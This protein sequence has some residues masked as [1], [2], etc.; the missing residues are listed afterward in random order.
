MEIK[1]SG[2]T[3]IK[4]NA[5]MGIQDKGEQTCVHLTLVSDDPSNP[6]TGASQVTTSLSLA[7]ANYIMEKHSFFRAEHALLWDFAPSVRGSSTQII[8]IYFVASLDEARKKGRLTKIFNALYRV[9]DKDTEPGFSFCVHDLD[10][11]KTRAL[12]DAFIARAQKIQKKFP[13]KK[14]ATPATVWR[15]YYKTPSSAPCAEDDSK[16]LW[17]AHVKPSGF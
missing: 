7:E 15:N 8:N 11:T 5:L 16:P 9:L 3:D 2:A 12:V 14:L 4:I 13:E 1:M 10:L 6:L 17:E